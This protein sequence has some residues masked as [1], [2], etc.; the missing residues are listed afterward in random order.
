MRQAGVLAAAG[1][2]ALEKMADRLSED[3]GRARR[4]ADGLSN[5]SG[6]ALDPGTPYTNMIFCALREDVPLNA[7]QV[8]DA[9][10]E[11]GVRVGV[12][13]RRSFRIVTHYW[14]GD[15]EVAQAIAAFKEVLWEA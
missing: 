8:A 7:T 13:G 9:L 3:H 5:I 11:R 12:T 10:A 2:V 6:I 1:I 4:L 14:I 15:A